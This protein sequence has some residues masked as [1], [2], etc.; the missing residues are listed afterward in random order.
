MF[1]R[2][3]LTLMAFLI[4]TLCHATYEISTAG[5]NIGIGTVTAPSPLTVVG[6]AQVGS[7]SS[8]GSLTGQNN[9]ISSN[10]GIGTSSPYTAALGVKGVLFLSNVVGVS[11][12]FDLD[13][14]NFG[15]FYNTATDSTLVY[16]DGSSYATTPNV[17]PNILSLGTIAGT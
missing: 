5:N 3:V 16:G 6:N 15:S 17:F 11:L 1:K 7:L 4:P 9:Y 12:A 10:V 14:A 13:G 2:I 8:T